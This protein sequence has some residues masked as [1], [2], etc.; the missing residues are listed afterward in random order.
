M[1]K[2]CECGCGLLA[3]ISRETDPKRGRVKG[4]PFRFRQGH[5]LR[6]R[7]GAENNSWI[8]GRVSDGN[9]YILIYKPDHPRANRGYVLEHTLIAEKAIGRYLPLS[10]E[11]HHWNE[12]RGDNQNSNLVICEDLHYHRLLHVRMRAYRACGNPSARKCHICKAWELDIPLMGG[13]RVH[14]ECKRRYDKQRRMRK[15]E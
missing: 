9:G 1:D 12:C 7:F 15:G 2:L 6:G 8:G 13:K 11:V 14:Y 4:Q 10:V 3:P 5:A